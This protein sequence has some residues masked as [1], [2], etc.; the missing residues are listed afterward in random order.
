VAVV[1]V[2]VGF[3]ELVDKEKALTAFAALLSGS[4]GPLLLAIP[5]WGLSATLYD[6]DK[7]SSLLIHILPALVQTLMMEA[8]FRAV[9]QPRASDAVKELIL[10]HL[11]YSNMLALHAVLFV[12]W[13]IY[14]QG[15]LLARAWVRRGTS[16]NITRLSSYSWLLDKPPGG[17]SSVLYRIVTIFGGKGTLGSKVM[18][19]VVQAALHFMFFSVMWPAVALSAHWMDVAPLLAII[20]AFCVLSIRNGA[21]LQK[22]AIQKLQKAAR[23]GNDNAAS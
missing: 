10:R 8:G 4:I 17:E 15:F 2:S 19:V 13:Q 7:I 1:P 14:H 22:R 3:G 6:R 9:A 18:F 16:D 20:L 11:S 5:I 21:I 12:A 23:A